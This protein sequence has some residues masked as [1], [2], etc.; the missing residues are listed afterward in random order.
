MSDYLT[1]WRKRCHLLEAEIARFRERE[2]SNEHRVRLAADEVCE[3]Y[4]EE[5]IPPLL[6]K[7]SDR[8]E[9]LRVLKNEH[10]NQD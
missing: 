9:A 4:E 3:W 1:Y 2:K 7:I 5:K 10:A 6:Q 8:D